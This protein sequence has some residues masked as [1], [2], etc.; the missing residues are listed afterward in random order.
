M[1]TVILETLRADIEKRLIDYYFSNIPF[2]E[3]TNFF[4]KDNHSINIELYLYED[5]EDNYM[6][7]Y[8]Y[9]DYNFKKWI[10]VDIGVQ[11]SYFNILKQESFK[12]KNDR[13]VY[14]KKITSEIIS[15]LKWFI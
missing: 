14:I 1:T 15:E 12:G 5:I 8:V 6:D 13:I 7:L 2:V 4:L 3:I 9:K 11:E 10:P